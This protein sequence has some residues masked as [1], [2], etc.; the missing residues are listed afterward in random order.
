MNQSERD[1]FEEE[2]ETDPYEYVMPLAGSSPKV[3]IDM[4]EADFGS[5]NFDGNIPRNRRGSNL[6]DATP[7]FHNYTRPDE[8]NKGELSPTPVYRLPPLPVYDQ[9][10]GPTSV[11]SAHSPNMSDFGG[12]GGS[13]DEDTEGN[14]ISQSSVN[15]PSNPIITSHGASYTTPVG[16]RRSM[17]EIKREPSAMQISF[18]GHVTQFP[19]HSRDHPEQPPAP[20]SISN[21]SESLENNDDDGMYDAQSEDSQSTV[22]PLVC[23]GIVMPMCIARAMKKPPSLSRISLFI[24][25][26]APC[27]W[28]CGRGLQGS[29][30]D[31]AVLTRLNVLALFFAL[32]Q[33][34][35][36]MW[37]ATVLLILDDT[38]GAL[39]GFSPHLWNLNGAV[40]SIG[41]FGFATIATC[42][43]TIRVIKE[44]DLVGAIRHLW[45]LLWLLPFECFFSIS[46]FDYFG[47]TEVWIKH[48]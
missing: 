29:S 4:G 15:T 14:S 42:I 26:T 24:V 37:L 45:V 16:N 8:F 33:L 40:F 1:R 13:Y 3:S 25:T 10:E 30:T 27:F 28:C 46:L 19:L 17:H 23:C 22:H 41:I 7:R 11:G 48:W 5:Q 21:H 20:N 35:A 47:V 9:T 34:V 2:T 32:F 6:T 12:D 39:S 44:V 43:C 36:A 31:R 18:D 38:P